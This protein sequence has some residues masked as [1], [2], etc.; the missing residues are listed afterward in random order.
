MPDGRQEGPLHEA[1]SD[2][3]QAELKRLNYNG[4]PSEFPDATP[5]KETLC[6]SA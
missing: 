2:P 3:G 1:G 6:S 5:T 4:V